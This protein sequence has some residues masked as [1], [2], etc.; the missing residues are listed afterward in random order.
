MTKRPPASISQATRQVVPKVAHRTARVTAVGNG[1]VDVVFDD[2]TPRRGVPF[3]G[4]AKVGEVVA[5]QIVN[6]KA[7]GAGA[8]TQG[9]GGGAITIGPPA[10][11]IEENT[12]IIIDETQ[13][14]GGLIV[15]TLTIEGTLIEQVYPLRFYNRYGAALTILGVFIAVG[16]AP[17][18]TALVVDVLKDGVTIFTDTNHR[19]QIAAD[20]YTDYTADVDVDDWAIDSYFTVEVVTASSALDLTVQIICDCGILGGVSDHGVLTGLA[21]DDHTLYLNTTR[22][23][24][25]TRHTLGTVVPHDNLGDLSNVVLSSVADGQALVYDADLQKWVNGTVSGGGGGSSHDPVT[26]GAGSDAALAL[27]GQELTLADVL[28]PTEH[29]AIGDGA[30]HHA[31]VTLDAN[32]ATLL[33]LPA[34]PSQVLGLA[35]Q[36]AHEVLIGRVD[37]GA[38]TVPT[39]R[40]LDVVDIPQLAHSSL[41]GIGSG[42]HH[43]AVTIGNSG[44]SA[45]L[46]IDANQVLTL[47]TIGVASITLV[48]SFTVDGLMSTAGLCPHRFYNLFGIARTISK[49]AISL[50]IAPTGAAVIVDVLK[51][52]VTIFTNQAH[53]PQIAA[54]AN[55]GETTTIDVASWVAGTYFQVQVSQYGSVVP[56]SHLTVQIVH[57]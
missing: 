25:T 36:D 37:A 57:G 30:P 42:D 28:T 31:A 15:S 53:R 34:S 50:G 7:I 23:D 2:G 17:A 10:L 19:P 44:A 38:A 39:F 51:D 29:T 9:E 49:V 54:G 26:L 16:T 6:G 43:A 46:G 56:G 13:G 35:V 45:L 5:V 33:A 41:S 11:T 20:A 40:I 32:A 8:S 48:T 24:T 55:Y 27:S 3:S 1:A 12:S 22:H 21:D 18:S 52:G 47:A 4:T 14:D